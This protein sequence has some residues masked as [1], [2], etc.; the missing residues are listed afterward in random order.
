[1]E[2]LNAGLDP[3]REKRAHWAARGPEVKEIVRE[4]TRQAATAAARTMEEVRG[5]VRLEPLEHSHG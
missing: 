4:G 1:M 3:I 2:T 5:A